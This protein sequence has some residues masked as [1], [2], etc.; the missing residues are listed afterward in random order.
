MRE[1][2]EE[3]YGYWRKTRVAERNKYRARSKH[4]R[5]MGT[6]GKTRVVERNKYRVRLKLARK[7][8]TGGKRELPRETSTVRD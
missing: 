2:L 3:I 8:G 6:G 7:T 4:V 1:E 5:K